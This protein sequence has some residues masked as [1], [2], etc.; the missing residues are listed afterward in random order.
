MTSTTDDNHSTTAAQHQ[1]K[2][3]LL[4]WH[5]S[6][7]TTTVSGSTFFLFSST[8]TGSCTRLLSIYDTSVWIKFSCLHCTLDLVG[9]SLG[10]FFHQGFDILSLGKGRHGGSTKLNY[11][12]SAE[13]KHIKQ[14]KTKSW[15]II[16]FKDTD[17]QLEPPAVVRRG[18]VQPEQELVPW[19]TAARNDNE[20]WNSLATNKGSLRLNEFHLMNWT[21]DSNNW[22]I[23]HLTATI[24]ELNT[25]QQQLMNWTL[26][27]NVLTML[28]SRNKRH[29]R[30]RPK[31]PK[32]SESE[33]NKIV[34]RMSTPKSPSTSSLSSLLWSTASWERT[35]SKVSWLDPNPWGTIQDKSNK[36]NQTTFIAARHITG[37]WDC[38]WNSSFCNRIISDSGSSK[39]ITSGG[40]G[41][42]GPASSGGGG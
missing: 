26:D 25:W 15:Q 32:R 8:V 39:T 31:K 27:S 33:K 11:W 28:A 10:G 5:D 2:Q 12:V 13:T 36:A 29:W 38:F 37:S 24:D 17:S 42:S 41:G 20:P 40:A 1:S 16:G 6:N 7:A 14:G 4:S 22:W 19:L 35:I 34:V 30:H 9:H 23:E 21:L 18:F 3:K